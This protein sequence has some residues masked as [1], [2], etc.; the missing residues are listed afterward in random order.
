MDNTKKNYWQSALVIGMCGNLL[1]VGAAALVFREPPGS[2]I[3]PMDIPIYLLVIA[4]VTAMSGLPR[5]G[6]S[7]VNDRLIL[8]PLVAA[9]LCAFTSIQRILCLPLF[10]RCVSIHVETLSISKCSTKQQESFRTWKFAL[11]VTFL[12]D[13]R[14]TAW[15][16]G[17]D[18]FLPRA[19]AKACQTN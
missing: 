7:L 16:K 17:S 8:L 1:A 13:S 3:R 4:L 14:T 19:I 12:L 15:R 18:N 11:A 5:A 10:C 2:A 9:L 6:L